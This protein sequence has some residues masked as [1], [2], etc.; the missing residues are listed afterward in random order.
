MFQIV[1]LSLPRKP[2]TELSA[3]T[4]A[5]AFRE[6][7]RE[8]FCKNLPQKSRAIAKNLPQSLPRKASAKPS[9]M[10]FSVFRTEF[11]LKYYRKDVITVSR[12]VTR[13]KNVRKYSKTP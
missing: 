3:K 11:E 9:V 5:K 12:S 1:F 4:F 2:S 6:T 7:F 10:R 13:S 8:A